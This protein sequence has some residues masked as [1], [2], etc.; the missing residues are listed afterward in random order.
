MLFV[1]AV[2]STVAAAE[3]HKGATM[4]VKV[5]SIWFQDAGKFDHWQNL[6]R[7]GNSAEAASYQENALSHRDAWQFLKPL[8]VKILAY[9]PAKHRVNVEMQTPGRMLGSTWFLDPNA[10]EP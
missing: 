8:T 7:S 3:I 9:E 1:L 2:I 5:N 10:L 6:E 4:Q